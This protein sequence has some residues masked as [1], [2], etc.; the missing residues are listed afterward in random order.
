MF[1]K[2]KEVETMSALL[3][4]FAFDERLKRL[5]QSDCPEVAACGINTLMQLLTL[6]YNLHHPKDKGGKN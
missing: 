4:E 5:A 2:E 3:Q 6:D 1:N